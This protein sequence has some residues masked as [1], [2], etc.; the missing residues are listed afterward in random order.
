MAFKYYLENFYSIN[1]RFYPNERKFYRLGKNLKFPLNRVRG[2]MPL[3][4][5]SVGPIK[6]SVLIL[7]HKGILTQDVVFRICIAWKTLI[8]S[9]N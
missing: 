3:C 9:L 5:F 8:E 4:D 1:V 7:Q 6:K 2:G